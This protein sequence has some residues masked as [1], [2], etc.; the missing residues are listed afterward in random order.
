MLGPYLNDSCRDGLEF[1]VYIRHEGT[2]SYGA[3]QLYLPSTDAIFIGNYAG[4]FCP[5]KQKRKT[6]IIMLAKE[7]PSIAQV[8]FQA[9]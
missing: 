4:C 7:N 5:E 6:E 8:K 2:I 9:V 1:A 3:A